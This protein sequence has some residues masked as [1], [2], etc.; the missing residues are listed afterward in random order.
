[1]VSNGIFTIHHIKLLYHGFLVP[2]F[3]NI[4]SQNFDEIKFREIA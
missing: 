2:P 4:H 3:G 1:M